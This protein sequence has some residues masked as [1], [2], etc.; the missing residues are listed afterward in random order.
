MRRKSWVN[1]WSVLRLAVWRAC[2]I[3]S[4][5]LRRF[6]L[7]WRQVVRKVGMRPSKAETIEHAVL[8]DG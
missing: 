1:S 4:R 8:E 6:I 7:C 2:S 3:R 5:R